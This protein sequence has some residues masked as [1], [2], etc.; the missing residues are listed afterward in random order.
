MGI[1]RHVKFDFQLRFS[2]KILRFRKSL[3]IRVKTSLFSSIL[4]TEITDDPLSKPVQNET[5]STDY[6]GILEKLKELSSKE[7]ELKKSNNSK[8]YRSLKN[9]VS[10]VLN[11]TSEEDKKDSLK[12]LKQVIE[13]D[14]S[15]SYVSF[16]VQD[17]QTG[18]TASAKSSALI[19]TDE[20]R[21]KLE[22]GAPG[23]KIHEIK[24]K[25]GKKALKKKKELE[26]NKTKG[27]A[28]YGMPATEVTEEIKNDLE[29]LQMRGALD[30]K[31]FYKKNSNKELPKYFQVGRYVNSPVEFYSD[32]GSGKNKKKSLV[33]EL[34]ADAEF[35][36]YNKRK[37]TEIIADKAKQMNKR[38]QKKFAKKSK[39]K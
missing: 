20:V 37:Y 35:Q 9:R 6:N 32:R 18:L 14:I 17:R 13:L 21:K 19:L 8:S 25:F 33:D 1:E 23:D 12:D 5:K 11:H 30:P 39:L 27:D 3:L 28:W 34:M 16:G 22:E 38:D 4:P 7:T 24:P 10:F 29:T 26:R 2:Q 31:R 36:R 15:D